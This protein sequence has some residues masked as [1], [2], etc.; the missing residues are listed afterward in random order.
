[1][2]DQ[3]DALIRL[4]N[5]GDEVTGPINIGNPMEIPMTELAERVL[6]LTGSHSKIEFRPLPSDD[7]KQRQPDISLARATLNWEPTT[8]L[9]VGLRATIDY[10]KQVLSFAA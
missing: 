10:F 3:V 7:P 2:N 5:T 9:E 1:M 4:M 8:E 6:R